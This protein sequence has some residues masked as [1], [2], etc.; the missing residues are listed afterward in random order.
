M[1]KYVWYFIAKVT[2]V[3]GSFFLRNHVPLEVW[4]RGAYDPAHALSGL[5]ARAEEV[6]C[7]GRMI[8]GRGVKG[9]S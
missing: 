4:G 3:G 6:V 8:E 9:N 2:I 5:R 1:V 7:R